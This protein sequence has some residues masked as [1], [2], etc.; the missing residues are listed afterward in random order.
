MMRMFIRTAR[1]LFSTEESIAT[2]SSVKAYGRLRSPILAAGLDVTI[3]DLQLS[4]SSFAQL[5]HEVSRESIRVSRDSL[6][7]CTRLDDEMQ[8]FTLGIDLPTILGEA[9]KY[10]L[11]LVVGTQTLAG[12]PE[13]TVKALF[14]NCA[15]IASYRVSGEDAEELVREFGTSGKGP[16]NP[17]TTIMPAAELQNLPRLQTVRSHAY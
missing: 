15:T 4:S 1:S 10:A 2:P 7:Q 3:C 12:I 16:I 14:G 5:E 9:R 11:G 13:H 8:N 6:N 17:D